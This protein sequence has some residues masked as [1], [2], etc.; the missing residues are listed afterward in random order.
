LLAF[1]IP[2]PFVFKRSCS[3]FPAVMSVPLFHEQVEDEKD[4]L[5]QNDMEETLSRPALTPSSLSKYL[6]GANSE[7][8]ISGH[9]NFSY[10][11]PSP[12]MSI[13]SLLRTPSGNSPVASSSSSAT[14]TPPISRTPQ[15]LAAMKEERKKVQIAAAKSVANGMNFALYELQPQVHISS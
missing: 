5:I 15:E 7:A 11:N 2:C 12:G 3:T 9:R 14:T 6:Q 10:D 8:T 13:R 1:S 4:R